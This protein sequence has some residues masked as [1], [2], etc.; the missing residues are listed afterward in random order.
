MSE[1]ESTPRKPTK[2]QIVWSMV[3][4]FCGIQ[5]EGNHDRDAAYIDQVGF[6]PYII[7]GVVLTLLFI[8]I[9]WF[10]VTLIL[11]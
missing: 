3:A 5:S 7:V 11:A 9:I 1:T 10:T 6:M 4:A 2:M 8:A